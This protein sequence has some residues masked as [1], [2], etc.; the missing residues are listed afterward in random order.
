MS[1]LMGDKSRLVA[2]EKSPARFKTLETM[3]AKAECG[4]I[5]A[6][7]AD[8]LESDPDDAD[9]GKVT[10]MYV[11]LFGPRLC[12]GNLQVSARAGAEGSR[13]LDPSCS[14]SGIVN[15]LDYLLENGIS[16]DIQCLRSIQSKPG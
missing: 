13:L 2:F 8:F 3:L 10:R 6:R 11:K 9:F 5:K 12:Q 15:R 1:A 4:N 16:S 7:R 14:G